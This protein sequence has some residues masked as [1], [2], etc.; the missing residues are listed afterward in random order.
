[1]IKNKA[2]SLAVTIFLIAAMAISSAFCA[3]A[4]ESDQS[5]SDPDYSLSYTNPK[6]GFKALVFDDVPLMTRDEA[7]K[8]LDDMKPITEYGNVAFWSTEESASSELSQAQKKRYGLFGDSSSSV[9]VINMKIRKLTVQS[10][11]AIYSVVTDSK[12]RSMTDNVSAK[13][14]NKDYY[15]A[16]K[17]IYSQMLTLLEGGT[18]S[19]PMKIASYIMLSLLAGMIAALAF[20]LSKRANP[21]VEQSK[22]FMPEAE[23]NQEVCSD[24][25]VNKTDSDFTLGPVPRLGLSILSLVFSHG[26]G[27]GG[28]GSSGG[29]GGCGGGGGGGGGGGCGGGGSS[30]F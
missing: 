3:S 30:S 6:T 20:V 4:A 25:T 14:G 17:E 24:K 1:M 21:L 5:T 16:S 9:F 29:G 12:A 18:I 7:K 15:G 10:Y 27:S 28:G 13:A 11:G 26:G 23:Q 2:F 19:E 22:Q 8:L